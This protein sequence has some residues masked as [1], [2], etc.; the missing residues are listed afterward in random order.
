MCDREP[1]NLTQASGALL[2]GPTASNPIWQ[3]ISDARDPSTPVWAPIYQDGAV[4]RV[5]NQ[6]DDPPLAGSAPWPQPRALYFHHPSDPVGYW[7]LQTLWSRPEWVEDPVGYDVSPE[8]S[9]FPFLTWGQVS[10]D[11]MAGFGAGP[12]FGHNYSVDFVSGWASV[13]PPGNWGDEDTT[14]LETHLAQ[15]PAPPGS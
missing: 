12:G 2:T 1:V 15:L 8:V 3:Q 4:V 10:V 5:A 14:R 7:N 6:P 13:A 11:L 9:W